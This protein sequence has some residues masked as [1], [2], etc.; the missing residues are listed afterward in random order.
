MGVEVIDER[1]HELRCADSSLA[2]VYDF[3]LRMP[4]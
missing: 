4:E 2:W 1:P 3:G